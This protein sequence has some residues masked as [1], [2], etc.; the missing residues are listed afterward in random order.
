MALSFVVLYHADGKPVAHWPVSPAVY[1]SVIATLSGILL[2]AAFKQSTGIYFWSLLLTKNGATLEKL[3]AVWSLGY[4]SMALV[5][6][7]KHAFRRETFEPILRMTGLLMILT[8]ATGPLLQRAV[9]IEIVQFR[10]VAQQPLVIRREPFCDFTTVFGASSG[11]NTPYQEEMA[12]VVNEYN[13]RDPIRL[14]S[15]ACPSDATCKTQAVVAGFARTCAASTASSSGISTLPVARHIMGWRDREPFECS[16]TAGDAASTSCEFLRT[17]Y[18]LHVERGTTSQTQ[19]DGGPGGIPWKASDLQPQYLNYTSYLRLSADNIVNDLAVRR[20]NFTTVFLRIPLEITQTD[21]VQID[22]SAAKNSSNSELEV[23]ESIPNPYPAEAESQLC[24]GSLLSGFEQAIRDLF[25]GYAFIDIRERTLLAHGLGPRQYAHVEP[26]GQIGYNGQFSYEL[27]FDDPLEDFTRS[28]NELSLRYA[29]KNVPNTEHRRAEKMSCPWG[30]NLEE[31][32]N[33]YHYDELGEVWK[34]GNATKAH[35]ERVSNLMKTKPSRQQM[36]E[37]T[38]WENVATYKARYHYAA[39]AVGLSCATSCFQLLLLMGWRKLGRTFSVS[40]LEVAKAF[41]APLMRDAGSNSTGEQ[42][43]REMRHLRVK[44]GEA[45]V[46]EK[47]QAEIEGQPEDEG[48]DGLN[49]SAAPDEYDPGSHDAPRPLSRST[50]LDNTDERNDEETRDSDENGEPDAD[51]RQSRGALLPD[52]RKLVI[53]EIGKISHA[54]RGRI[55]D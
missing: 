54:V 2:R 50:S 6:T 53:G 21:L 11:D 48:P 44:Y 7:G 31:E 34:D 16:F 32:A 9:D 37:V 39:I 24:A 43:A 49:E 18:Q 23:L 45:Q 47:L 28:L 46:Q 33:S 35:Q 5:P 20:C 42:I 22:W 27:I 38:K 1:L 12:Q 19:P 8:A 36:L 26:I 55:Y 52:K 40:P 17:Q 29:M 25:A 14:P 51:A 15:P 13:R 41:D 10:S 4:S 30:A 3:Q